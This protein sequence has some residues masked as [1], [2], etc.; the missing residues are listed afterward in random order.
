MAPYPDVRIL[1]RCEICK[2]HNPLSYISMRYHMLKS[3][4]THGWTEKVNA[5][6]PLHL[7]GGIVRKERYL[8]VSKF[9]SHFLQDAKICARNHIWKRQLYSMNC[10]LLY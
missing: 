9:H 2:K 7:D 6:C 4:R 1:N 8:L 3:G 5:I 10:L